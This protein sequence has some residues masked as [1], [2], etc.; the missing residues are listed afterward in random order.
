VPE[1]Q[2]K[3][4]GKLQDPVNREWTPYVVEESK[5]RPKKLGSKKRSKKRS[6]LKKGGDSSPRKH[7]IVKPVIR[8]SQRRSLRK[9]DAIRQRKCEQFE[10]MP[11][12]TKNA[13][14][15]RAVQVKV[16]HKL[17]EVK[18]CILSNEEKPQ[19]VT[20]TYSAPKKMN[21]EKSKELLQMNPK[22]PPGSTRQAR[23]EPIVVPKVYPS[24]EKLSRKKIRGDSIKIVRKK[25]EANSK[26]EIGKEKSLADFKGESN[27]ES[28]TFQVNSSARSNWTPYQLKSA[29]SRTKPNVNTSKKK[30]SKISPPVARRAFST[31]IS[32]SSCET[33]EV[34]LHRDQQIKQSN[35]WE[36]YIS[37]EKHQSKIKSKAKRNSM[38]ER[39]HNHVDLSTVASNWQ[40]Y[41]PKPSNEESNPGWKL[42][43][44]AS[45]AK[46]V[47]ADTKIET[48]KSGSLKLATSL[49]LTEVRQ[50]KNE[51][52]IDSKQEQIIS[53]WT[54]YKSNVSGKIGATNVVKGKLKKNYKQ[55]SGDIARRPFQI[56]VDKKLR[57]TNVL[58]DNVKTVPSKVSIETTWRPYELNVS[59]KSKVTIAVKT[60][61][62][63]GKVKP[64][65]RSMKLISN[66]SKEPFTG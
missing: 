53:N 29:G 63:R 39:K 57:A 21:E 24:T 66:T 58:K 37:E 22:G 38:K 23:Q 6:S 55:Q 4:I 47:K 13:F 56:K 9:S 64:S 34:M 61:L 52:K 26:V 27:G 65:T 54:P 45:T 32:S 42:K 1:E 8:K 19:P 44:K 28:V 14:N 43:P 31:N 15:S 10:K 18:P 40:P 46:V 17:V 12:L 60:K 49:K 35:R 51:V 7:N 11:S 25:K 3:P 2:S 62:E 33:D 48:R 16:S 20:R 50:Q 30:K 36:P 59:K 41:Q 5:S